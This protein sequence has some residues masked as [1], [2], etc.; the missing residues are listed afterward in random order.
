MKTLVYV[1]LMTAPLLAQDTGVQP[2]SGTAGGNATIAQGILG[3]GVPSSS[4]APEPCVGTGTAG[5]CYGVPAGL[6]VVPTNLLVP[7]G[8]SGVFYLSL[9]TADFSGTADTILRLYESKAEVLRMEVTG[10]TINANAKTIIARAGEIPAGTYTGPATLTASTTVTPQ[11]GGA[12][13]TLTAS[14]QLYIVPP[15]NSGDGPDTTTDVGLRI[16]QGFVGFGIPPQPSGPSACA[17]NGESNFCYG[18]PVGV[19][20]LP[21]D[22]FVGPTIGGVYYASIQTANANGDGSTLF[23]FVQGGKVVLQFT[24]DDES[25][26]GNRIVFFGEVSGIP[27]GAQVG[28]ATV[29][30]TTTVAPRDGEPPL[31]TLTGGII[32]QIVQ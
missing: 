6:L 31:P 12:P 24:Q 5:F 28:P 15:P 8:T 16:A 13:V 1:V 26:L 25:V 14:I 4:G 29:I 19:A 27:A 20:V 30:I 9:E 23:Q 21:L 18:V 3:F 2:E 17:G 22:L 32:L 10:S 11:G 7:A